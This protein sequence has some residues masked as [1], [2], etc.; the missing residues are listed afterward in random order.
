MSIT[1]SSCFYLLNSKFHPHR[2][3]EWM[4]N[5]ISIV[6]NFNLVIY[7]NEE[8]K[9]HINTNNN[10]RILVVVKPFEEFYNYKYKDNWINNHQKN[11]SIS[12]FSDWVL[13][14]LWS[15]KI[16]FVKETIDKKYF[17]TEL[18]GWCDIGY[19]RNFGNDTHTSLLQNWAN[20]YKLD[21]VIDKT[22]ISYALV[23]NDN[24]YVNNIKNTITNTNELGLPIIPIPSDQISIGGGFFILHKDLINWWHETYDNKLQLYLKNNYLVKD[25]Q[26]ILANCIFSDD[27]KDRFILFQE[28]TEY[29][30]WFMFQRILQ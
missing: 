30:N 4:N 24:N 8:S 10:P 22:K 25:D 21:A 1:F 6:N 17:E 9:Q 20:S 3:I 13:N 18:Y 7:T 26:I 14:M 11:N 23:N 16:S 12:V 19:F 2:Y 29:N 5:F 27:N 15:E 28:N